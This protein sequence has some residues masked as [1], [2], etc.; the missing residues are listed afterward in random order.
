[1]AVQLTAELVE[2]CVALVRG[3]DTATSAGE[4]T[5]TSADSLSGEATGSEVDVQA[6]N[7]TSD[8]SE[9]VCVEEVSMLLPGVRV[10]LEWVAEQEELWSPVISRE[11][12][13]H[14]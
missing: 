1:M 6:G 4:D 3:E 2:R 9:G 13:T 14:L 12:R 7:L 11:N 5:A 8:L 10:W